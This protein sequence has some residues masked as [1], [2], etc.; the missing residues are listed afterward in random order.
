MN[1]NELPWTELTIAL[2]LVGAGFA[3]TAR[4]WEGAWKRSLGFVLLTLACSVM[5]LLA[6]EADGGQGRWDPFASMGLGAPLFAVDGLSAPLLPLV[7]LLHALTVL[8]TPRTKGTRTSFVVLMAGEAIQLATFACAEPLP[9]MALLALGMVPPAFELA[10]RR[11][12][13]RVYALHAGLFVALMATAIVG[14]VTGAGWTVVVLMLAV[15]VRSGT[16]PAHLWVG[17]LFEKAFGTAMLF[18]APLCGTYA[19]VR[20]LVPAAPDWVLQGIGL[21][22]LVTA[23]YSAGMA[24]VQRD[25]RRLLSYLFLSHASL[26]LVGMELHTAMSL[27]GALCLWASVVLSLGG[28]GLTLRAMEARFGRLTLRDYHGLYGQ[29]PALA[30]CFAMTGLASVGFPGTLGFVAAE[31]LV[32][33]AVMAAPLIG[34][35]LILTA[36]VNG[37]AILRAYLLLFT[38]VKREFSVPLQITWRERFAVLTLAGLILGGGLIPQPGVRDRHAAAVTLQKARA[39]ALG[40]EEPRQ[41]VLLGGDEVKAEE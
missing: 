40:R 41:T 12:G 2:P 3:A 22:S 36:A 16:V 13:V 20:L 24:A 29:S 35:A 15:L 19:A 1:W 34:V 32:D 11:R 18:M 30:V 31:L 9:L 33:G 6:F 17:D 25:A 27:T 23:L 4:D 5:P 39:E 38:G 37:I 14:Q 26:V 7:A 21:A 10:V 8:A 28:M